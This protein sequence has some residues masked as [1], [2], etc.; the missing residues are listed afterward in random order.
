M[1]WVTEDFSTNTNNDRKYLH[2]R[3][4]EAKSVL[5]KQIKTSSIRYKAIHI[6]SAKTGNKHV[7]SL[8]KVRM[9]PHTWWK[10]VGTEVAA[11]EY[12]SYNSEEQH[13][14]NPPKEVHQ[15]AE[16]VSDTCHEAGT[17][18]DN[19]GQQL[20]DAIVEPSVSSGEGGVTPDVATEGPAVSSATTDEA[21]IP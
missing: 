5:G 14:N 3:L 10:A 17:S 20:L 19:G 11:R 15:G 1:K 13:T 18:D 12:D 21:E 4:Q 7:F 16:D 8:N 9:S 2:G 6:V